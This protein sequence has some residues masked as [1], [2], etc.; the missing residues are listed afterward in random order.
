MRRRSL[1]AALAAPALVAAGLLAYACRPTS[2]EAGFVATETLTQNTA[3]TAYYFSCQAAVMGSGS[4]TAAIGAWP[5]NDT[6]G[7]ATA[8]DSTGNGATGHYVGGVTLGNSS[9]AGNAATL[10]PH[11]SNTTVAGFDGSTGYME[12]A[13][14]S[15]TTT[16]PTFT[17]EGW[18]RTSTASGW[19][20]GV[21]NNG[22]TAGVPDTD[23]DRQIYFGS[24]GNLCFGAYT[25]SS[26]V[27]ICAAASTSSTGALADNVWHYVAASFTSSTMT[28]FLDGTQV[29]TGAAPTIPS[30]T[31]W[32]LRGAYDSTLT[33]FVSYC[34]Y[35]YTGY[36]ARLA[37]YTYA[38]S[39][40]Q[41]NARYHVGIGS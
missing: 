21:G 26:D 19:L 38:L 2:S 4:S 9:S 1:I 33:G 30:M 18:F 24:S 40:S 3:S 41:I 27:S 31:T 11:D 36:L 14:N 25:G 29:A 8:A 23:Y 15:A 22:T 12:E 16:L 28:L 17:I 32:Y 37:L 10:C 20:I 34:N 5:L 6:S 35:H 7:S 39:G 13:G